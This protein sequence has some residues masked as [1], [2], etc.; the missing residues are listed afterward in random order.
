[1]KKL[2]HLACS[3]LILL[4]A[5]AWADI[6]RDSAIATAQQVTAGR[7]LAVEKATHDGRPVWRVKVLT[8]QAEVKVVLVDAIS[9]RRL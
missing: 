6:S 5:P 3:L 8:P 9:G 2:A 1:M 7:V 4:A